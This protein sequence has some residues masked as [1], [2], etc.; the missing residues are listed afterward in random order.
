MASRWCRCSG[1]RSTPSAAGEVAPPEHLHAL[2]DRLLGPG[3]EQHHAHVR[4][5]V[6]DQRARHLEQGDHAGR[7]C[8]WPPAPSRARRCRRRREP[9]RRRRSCRPRSAGGCRGPNRARPEPGRPARGTSAAGWCRCARSAT[10]S[11]ARRRPEC[12][13]GRSAPS[14]PRRDARPGAPCGSRPAGPTSA[15]TFQ[16]LRLG[17]RRR[18]CRSP[19][20]RSSQIA[21]AAAAPSA[22]PAMRWPRPRGEAGQRSGTREQRQRQP[23][24]AVHLLGLDARRH[25]DLLEAPHDPLRGKALAL[26][27]RW[28]VDAREVGDLLAQLLVR[29]GAAVAS[30]GG[31]RQATLIA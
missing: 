3:R 27:G 5:R 30:R 2:Q 17:S 9:L 8:R 7:R 20:V 16:A 18:K 29:R 6:L 31:E 12:R 23:V 22:V 24:I 25:A 1:R 14:E 15:T 13:G 26:R 11:G 10:G 4:G 19:A 28:A 21:A